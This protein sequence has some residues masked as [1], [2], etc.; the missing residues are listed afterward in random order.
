M[1]GE[2]LDGEL[3]GQ[4]LREQP[5]RLRVL[6]VPERVHLALLVARVLREHARELGAP[7]AMVGLLHQH[8]RVEQFVEQDRVPR[9]VVGRPGGR[10][11]Q[12]GQPG[13]QR[14]MLDDEREIGA[15]A[16]DGLEQ[17]EQAHEGRLRPAAARARRGG[18]EHARHQLVEPLLRLR[19]QRGVPRPGA[20]P[21]ERAEQRGRVVEARALEP[22]D[23]LV[24]DVGGVP[25]AAPLGVGAGIG[26]RI[27]CTEHGL[28]LPAGLE[29]VL[30][31]RRAEVR[32]RPEPRRARECVEL[33]RVVGQR[34]RLL[35][36]AVLQPVLGVAQEHVGGVERRGGGLRK[37]AARGERRERRARVA[38]A[39]PRLAPPSHDLQ[40]LD[41]ELD[42][43]DPAGAQLHVVARVAPRRL[44]ADLAVDVAQAGVRVVVE[45]LAVDERPDDRVELL[46]R[47]A[48]QRARLEPRI[49]LPGAALRHQVVLERRVRH[50]E[51]PALAVGA[52][53]HVDAEHESLGGRV[54]DRRDQAPT[55]PVE[56][57]A[58]RDDARP[59][60]LAF[61]RVEE[62]EIDV[63]RDV[64]LAAAELA[65]ADD[66][67]RLGRAAVRAEG[68]AVDGDELAA[69]GLD[70]GIDRDLGEGGHRAADLAEAGAAG[71][72]A[73]ERVDHDAGAQRA[74]RGAEGAR[75]VGPCGGGVARGPCARPVERGVERRRELAGP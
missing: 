28:E 59:G 16:R 34:L 70:G 14:R 9:Q 54:V 22:G 66:D 18:G 45:V 56:E 15:A 42:L 3:A 12:P 5:E 20:R 37:V 43:A 10:A 44:L 74:Q 4:V 30:V 25:H 57:L 68:L 24:G 35:V 39:Q 29:A 46:L 52:Q 36:V 26:V 71:E 31:E 47:H 65:H 62:H 8:A 21:G 40:R 51:R 72:V 19:G 6:E 50:R 67:Q 7:R 38:D 27:R 69:R 73:G 2:P 11:H 33:A 32:R 41:D 55:E 23:V 49:A 48:G 64:E 63:G 58:V 60:G 75:C 61:L 53:A 17:R 13:N 1:V